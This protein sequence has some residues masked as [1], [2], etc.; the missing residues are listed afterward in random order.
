MHTTISSQ[1]INIFKVCHNWVV[2]STNKPKS[3]DCVAP[4]LPVINLSDILEMDNQKKALANK[5]KVQQRNEKW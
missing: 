2:W 5:V 1:H 3:C 4:C